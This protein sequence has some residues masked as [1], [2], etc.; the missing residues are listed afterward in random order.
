M[1]YVVVAVYD[2]A[3]G[4]HARPAFV[5]SEGEA[6]RT[7]S[8]EVN[9]NAVDNPMFHHPEHFSLVFLGH[10]FDDSGRFVLPEGDFP[11]ELA[12]ADLVMIN[13]PGR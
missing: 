6:I 13:P 7:F 2:K 5:R 8:D 12:R 1:R 3:V 9:R 4:A 11:K 10:Y